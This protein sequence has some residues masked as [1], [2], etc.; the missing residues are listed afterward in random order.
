MMREGKT[1][2]NAPARAPTQRFARF[3]TAGS[4]ETDRTKPTK[5]KP[6]LCKLK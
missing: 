4:G 3:K 1:R 5:I 2:V 6:S